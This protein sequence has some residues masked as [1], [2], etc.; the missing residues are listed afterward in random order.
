MALDFFFFFFKLS[1]MDF[2]KYRCSCMALLFIPCHSVCDL[3]FLLFLQ[4]SPSPSL[5]PPVDGQSV[6]S[7]L[8]EELSVKPVV[9]KNRDI[10]V[11]AAERRHLSCSVRACVLR[12]EPPV[13][14]T[15]IFLFSLCHSLFIAFSLSVPSHFLPVLNKGFHPLSR[16]RLSL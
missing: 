3:I 5:S 14:L 8:P 16:K 15:L 7:S 2:A 4:S 9:D 11:T 12:V 13:F 6:T 1:F 10:D